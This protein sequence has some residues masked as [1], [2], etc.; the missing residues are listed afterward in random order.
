LEIGGHF[1]KDGIG[2]V[3]TVEQKDGIE[4]HVRVEARMYLA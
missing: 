1:V 2:V 3:D 4:N